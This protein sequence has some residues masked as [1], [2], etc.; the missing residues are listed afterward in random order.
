[1]RSNKQDSRKCISSYW[2][3]YSLPGESNIT[4]KVYISLKR[5]L[6]VTFNIKNGRIQIYK[7]SH[8]VKFPFG[9]IRGLRF[10]S[11]P[12]LY[13]FKKTLVI[14]LKK[15]T[16]QK[17]LFYIFHVT[18]L[19]FFNIALL[20]IPSSSKIVVGITYI[21]F[22]ACLTAQH[23]NQTFIVATKPMVYF[24]IFFSGEASEEYLCSYK[25]YT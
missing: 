6:I 1:M 23:V 9:G 8:P 16:L 22:T 5:L 7:C 21:F 25:L 11:Q 19:S 14:T 13:V 17:L 24:R 20:V 2:R 12:S 3:K 18:T 4:I 10:I 15:V